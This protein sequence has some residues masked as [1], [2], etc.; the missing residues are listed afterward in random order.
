MSQYLTPGTYRCDTA[1]I[2]A[3]EDRMEAG[4]NLDWLDELTVEEKVACAWVNE[5]L[6]QQTASDEQATAAFVGLVD[7]D[8]TFV[9]EVTE[10]SK[11]E[12]SFVE[13]DTEG[14]NNG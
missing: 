10:D 5:A 6:S 3:I 8:I 13:N 12:I 14:E 11:I 4:E 1:S 7:L 2:R 9:A